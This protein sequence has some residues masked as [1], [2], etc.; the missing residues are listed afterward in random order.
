MDTWIQWDIEAAV[1]ILW[2]SEM[3]KKHDISPRMVVEV[4]KLLFQTLDLGLYELS[5]F[6]TIPCVHVYGD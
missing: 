2:V 3:E 5:H 6:L 4:R 1:C